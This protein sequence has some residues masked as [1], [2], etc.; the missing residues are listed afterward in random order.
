MEDSIAPYVLEE[1]D[2]NVRWL[3]LNRPEQRNPLSL[4][5]IAAIRA[6]LELSLI[7]I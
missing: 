5:M 4:G 7:H 3:T 1:T 6:A 2:A